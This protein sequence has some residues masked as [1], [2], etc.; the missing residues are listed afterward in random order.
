MTVV[1]LGIVSLVT[2]WVAKSLMPAEELPYK[3]PLGQIDYYSYN[4]R[5]VVMDETG[6]AKDQLEAEKLIHYEQD[7]RTELTHPKMTLYT[8]KGPPWIIQAESAN[9]MD[10]GEI[11]FL[12]GS[13]HVLR[14]ADENGR[15]IHI[16]TSEVRVKPD[17][18]Y[19]ETDQWIQVASPPDTLTGVGA[20]V[21]FGDSLSYT[22]LSKVRRQH[23]Y[24]P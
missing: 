2:W 4:L 8:K 6:Q 1:V 9:T 14:D 5:R 10:N 20:Q 24:V 16:E 15:A 11:V 12:H 17:E 22:V 3:P 18:Q 21:H 13:V 23:E 7:N 19:A